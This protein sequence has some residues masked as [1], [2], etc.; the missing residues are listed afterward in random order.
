MSY[1]P[2]G[3]EWERLPWLADRPRTRPRR[4]AR[5]ALPAVLVILLVADAAGSYAAGRLSG[6]RPL[7]AHRP[8]IERM[9]ADE[10]Q[11]L[12]EQIAVA[13]GL[14]WMRRKPAAPY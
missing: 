14:A 11:A 13:E 4:G 8:T 10:T 2:P 7:I 3:E 9:T 5:R 12:A 1:C 6:E